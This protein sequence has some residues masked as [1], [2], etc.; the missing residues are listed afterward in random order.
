MPRHS[1]G[2]G[3][4]DC[5]TVGVQ[6]CVCSVGLG[7]L[8][9]GDLLVP[10]AIVGLTGELQDPQGHLLEELSDGVGAGVG[11]AFPGVVVAACG[12]WVG[13]TEGVLEVVQGHPE[14]QGEGGVGVA[15]HVGGHGVGDSR[16]GGQA[17]EGGVGVG[18]GPW[19]PGAGGED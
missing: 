3:Y 11:E 6:Q 14:V 9:C 8:G 19:G 18:S 17:G 13:V 16:A 4:Q 2:A 1:T 15:Q 12:A 7:Q 5:C 10:P